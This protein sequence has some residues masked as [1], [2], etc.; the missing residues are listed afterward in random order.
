MKYL[1][2]LFALFHNIGIE[3]TNNNYFCEAWTVNG[4]DWTIK[5]ETV[6]LTASIADELLEINMSASCI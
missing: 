3:R 5:E 1:Y 6:V 2:T 4:A